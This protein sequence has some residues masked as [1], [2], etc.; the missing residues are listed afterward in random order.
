[1]ILVGVMC[2]VYYRQ[3]VV[4]VQKMMFGLF[5]LGLIDGFQKKVSSFGYNLISKFINVR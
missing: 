4:N 3:C 5:G 1:M 2:S